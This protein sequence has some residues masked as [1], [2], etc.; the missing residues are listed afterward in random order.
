MVRGEKD[1]SLIHSCPKSWKT[2]RSA[3]LALLL[4]TAA[5]GHPGTRSLEEAGLL[6]CRFRFSFL[7][8][9]EGADKHRANVELL[10]FQ[11]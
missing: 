10:P 4:P 2:N 5:S 8:C 11:S 6:E 1:V 3:V 7:L 9:L